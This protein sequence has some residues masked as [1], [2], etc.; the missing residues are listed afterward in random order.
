MNKSSDPLIQKIGKYVVV[1]VIG[2]GGMGIVYLAEHADFVEIKSARESFRA[3]F[4]V[5][6]DGV[7]SPIAKAAGWSDRI[8]TVEVGFDSRRTLN[9]AVPPD[10]VVIRPLVGETVMPGWSLSALTQA[11]SGASRPL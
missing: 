2:S 10:S 4:V 11:T 3:K 8:E 1:D 6:A 9:V 5:A 7:H